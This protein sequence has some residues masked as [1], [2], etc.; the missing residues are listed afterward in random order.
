MDF[1]K[2]NKNSVL[3]IR[4]NYNTTKH[5]IPGLYVIL[6]WVA[7]SQSMNL[8]SRIISYYSSL[9]IT[10]LHMVH[11]TVG[12]VYK[13]D[14]NKLFH[15][16]D[17]QKNGCV[18]Y[19]SMVYIPNKTLQKYT[20]T[21]KLSVYEK[22]AIYNFVKRITKYIAASSVKNIKEAWKVSPPLI[23]GSYLQKMALFI[24]FKNKGNLRGCIGTTSY[25]NDL[26]TNI[27]KYT[28][29]AGFNDSRKNL[30][31]TKPITPEEIENGLT[32]GINLI[33]LPLLIS[34]SNKN[35]E[36]SIQK[37]KIGKD[38]IMMIDRQTNKSAMFL[39]S[40]PLEM[41][42]NIEDTMIHLSNKAGL[43]ADSWKKG[44]VELFIL[45]EYEFGSHISY[46]Y[47]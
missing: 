45:P 40:V 17:K 20:L 35:N 32:I 26:L 2:P 29:E 23:S 4:K 22:H 47:L 9:H 43:S 36:K 12:G 3:A 11:Q 19:L 28:Y 46:N 10:E 41:N 6:L 5:S 1:I 27:I 30:T 14:I 34:K 38:G 39:S 44:S 24:S 33:E 21:K 15:R 16:F 42:W 25:Q 7:I 13:F 8:T 31:K 18:S 37:W